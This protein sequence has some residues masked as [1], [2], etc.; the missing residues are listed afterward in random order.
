MN[1]KQC[2]NG[3]FYDTDAYSACPHCGAG[4]QDDASET[5]VE[6]KK[7][8]LFGRKSK[9]EKYVEVSKP[10]TAQKGGTIGVFNLNNEN[11]PNSQEKKEVTDGGIYTS[12]QPVEARAVKDGRPENTPSI[13]VPP[14]PIEAPSA[15]EVVVPAT[16]AAVVL[17]ASPALEATTP[18]QASQTGTYHD[19]PQVD[20][21]KS[22]IQKVTANSQGK[23]VGFF[24]SG[25]SSDEES[26]EPVVGW[27]VCV[28]G[29]HFGESFNIVAGKNSIGRSNTN[30]IVFNKDEKV[31]RER[32]ASITYEPNHRDFYVQPGDSSGLTYVNADFL[33]ETKKLKAFDALSLGGGE[34]ILVPLCG[35]NFTWENY[36]NKE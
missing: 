11:N 4:A 36:I 30:R 35:E 25:V 32:H 21:L 34:Y 8:S 22:A 28:K 12:P 26:Q 13:S 24:S 9:V 3:H 19:S 2:K 29:K 15:P 10:T 16:P 27:L 17:T 14:M 18:A 23:T 6:H 33:I 31:S 1:I 20:S 5:L 7:P